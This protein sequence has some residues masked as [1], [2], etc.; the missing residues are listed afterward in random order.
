MGSLIVVTGPPGA[1]KSTV[2]QVLARAADHSVRVDG[3]SFFGFLASGALDPWLAASHDQNTV[4][5]K[6]AAAAAGAFARGGYTTV[7]DGV[8]GPWFL[9]TFAAATHLDHLDYVILLPS[10]ETCVRR[11]V[12]RRDHGFTDEPAARKMHAEFAGAPIGERHVLR[13]PPQDPAQVAMLIESA[14]AAGKLTH[15][16]P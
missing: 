4:V 7:Y 16:T 1:G 13:D 6:A 2:A 3:D 12:T 10:V 5:T 11:V 14:R 15:A 8:V 9:S